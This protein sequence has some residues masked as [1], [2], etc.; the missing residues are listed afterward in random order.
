MAEWSHTVAN[1]ACLGEGGAWS[2]YTPTLTQSGSVAK[3]VNH[4]SYARFGR[5][6][7]VDV[8]LTA[9]ASGSSNNRITVSL[10]VT[11]AS[12]AVGGI[13]GYWM[14]KDNSTG[15][16]EAQG[17]GVRIYTSTTASLSDA[18]GDAGLSASDAPNTLASGDTVWMSCIYEA[19][20]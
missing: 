13:S 14:I 17:S 15:D 7:V 2:T 10:P 5:M 19:A 20:S 18:G 6:I 9:T 1:D 8:K 4:A 12:A 16:Y 3:T 11:A